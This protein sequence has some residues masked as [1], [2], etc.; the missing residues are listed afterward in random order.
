MRRASGRLDGL[1]L[2]RRWTEEEGRTAVEGLRASGLGPEE[3]AAR[4]KLHPVRVARW[5]ARLAPRA[6]SAIMPVDLVPARAASTL[7]ELV[8]EGRILR[9]PADIDSATLA[10]LIRVVEAV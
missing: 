3:F 8:L 1:H 7:V 9:V 10:R 6:L 5:A 2:I 4:H